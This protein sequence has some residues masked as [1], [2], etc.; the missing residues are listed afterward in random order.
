MV[1]LPD[2]VSPYGISGTVDQ[3]SFS[4]HVSAFVACAD[5][6][7]PGQARGYSSYAI[8]QDLAASD[9]SMNEAQGSM[10]GQLSQ[11]QPNQVSC[12]LTNHFLQVPCMDRHTSGAY[13]W[14]E[15]SSDN[16][17]CSIGARL[18]SLQSRD[19]ALSAS[20]DILTTSYL[21]DIIV[22]NQES[23]CC[24]QHHS[25]TVYTS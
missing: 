22:T 9:A 23:T 11:D 21:H 15:A 7:Q 20:S 2:E 17:Y 18:V 6:E 25:D 14:K 4:Q 1:T 16:Q 12:L 24:Q 10:S 8:T 5:L 3:Q 19:S 13:V